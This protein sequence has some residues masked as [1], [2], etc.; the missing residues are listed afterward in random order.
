MP[1][2]LLFKEE[3]LRLCVV[4]AFFSG[5]PCVVE[6]LILPP[7]PLQSSASWDCRTGQNNDWLC[8]N[9]TS[10]SYS[11]PSRIPQPAPQPEPDI[12]RQMALPVFRPEPALPE[13]E[14]PAG[15][16]ISD[17]SESAILLE[18]LNSPDN[19]YVLQWMAANE[20]QSL[21]E[22]KQRYPILRDA[23]IAQYRRSD[24]DWF[25]LLDGPYPSRVAA[26][27]AL[28]SSPRTQM[29]RELYPWTR[30]VASIQQLNLI[31]PDIGT[32]RLA[33]RYANEYPAQA[34][35]EVPATQPAIA[36]TTYPSPSS[37]DI[38]RSPAQESRDVSQSVAYGREF[39][40]ISYP[41]YPPT[42]D[43]Q[44]IREMY[45]SIEPAYRSRLPEVADEP[46]YNDYQPVEPPARQSYH[47]SE[48]FSVTPLPS[49]DV[50]SAE[51]GSYT[52]EWMASGRRATLE[53]AQRRYKEFNDTQILHYRRYN[54]DRYVLV[55]KIFG[56][57]RDAV[58]ALSRPSLSR[59]SARLTPRVRQIGYLQKL[60]DQI[61]Q[62]HR[63]T[64]KTEPVR[65]QRPKP[66]YSQPVRRVAPTRNKPAK[67]TAQ[68]YASA[69]KIRPASDEALYSAPN[70]SYT[71]QWFAANNIE[72]VEKMQARFPE[73]KHART[74]H[75]RRNQKDWYVLLQGQFGNSAEAI[76]AIKNPALRQAMLV[77]HPWTRPVKSLKKLQIVSR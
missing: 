45:A 66:R 2:R 32:K 33:N 36:N 63:Q 62:K 46:D 15:L 14:V 17:A 49:E 56:N 8:Q 44:S 59:V 52:I 3:Q 67:T 18:L 4:A 72:S 29:A 27:A 16:P 70:N 48:R 13:R 55:S 68:R 54:R 71:I 47:S 19:H 65:Y 31:R 9:K 34:R 61:P 73:L 64:A 77:L 20:R 53:R 28:Q 30:S 11:E 12:P 23:T 43:E 25:V 26:M 76:A 57:R 60:V 74:V 6:A 21:E 39:D 40:N 35:F 69:P 38:A 42:I 1:G 58:G 5:T 51:P 50:L 7:E 10:A 75:F 41:S 22:V 37:Y 24:K